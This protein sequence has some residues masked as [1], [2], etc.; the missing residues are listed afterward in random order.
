MTLFNNGWVKLVIQIVTGPL[1]VAGTTQLFRGREIEFTR[2]PTIIWQL[3]ACRCGIVQMSVWDL[4]TEDVL[5]CPM[6]CQ[7][8]RMSRRFQQ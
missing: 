5:K 3:R 1:T 6:A 2:P 8:R 7:P 4:L